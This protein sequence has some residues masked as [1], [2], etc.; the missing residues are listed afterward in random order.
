MSD[1]HPKVA[2][3]EHDVHELIRRRWSP[4]AFDAHRVVPRDDLLKLFEA[5]RW[6]PSSFNEQPWHFVVVDRRRTP[7]V[8]EALIASLTGRNPAWASSAPLLVLVAVRIR[9][10]GNDTENA[11]AWYDTG[12][13]V[14][15]LTL[16]ATAEGLSIRQMRG[17]EPEAARA[18]CRIP[19]EFVPA[20]VMAVGY[21]GDPETLAHEGH[22]HA[23]QQPRERR[24]VSEFVYDGTWGQ[25]FA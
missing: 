2:R 15:N 7:A 16:Q 5:A 21:A 11:H 19:P 24:P 23:E 6:T 4:R 14:A 22:R 25:A 3:T 1:E 9:H 20:V 18:A 8:S 12:Q 13:A 17:F 10:A